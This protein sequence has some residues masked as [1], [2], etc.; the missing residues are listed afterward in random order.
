MIL[1]KF[2]SKINLNSNFTIL[3]QSDSEDVINLVRSNLGFDKIKKRFPKKQTLADIFSL[4]INCDKSIEE[5]I[6]KDYPHFIELLS[7][8]T[9]IKQEYSKFKKQN[10]MLDYDDLLLYLK[11]LLEENLDFRNYI[12]RTYKFIMVDEYQDTNKLQADLVVLLGGQTKNVMVVGDDSQSIYSFRGANFRNI[13][14]FPKQFPDCKII[15]LEENYRSTQSILNFTNEIIAHAKEK[16]P[17]V[18]FTKND[19]GELPSLISAEDDN[20]QSKFVVDK[21]LEL[22]EEGVALN[23]IAVLFRSGFMSYDLEIE[24]NKAGIPFRKFGGLKFI[25]TAHIK[26]LISYLRIIN[27]PIDNISWFRVLLLLPGIGPVKAKRIIEIILQNSKQK[28]FKYQNLNLGK[29]KSE[30]IEKLFETLDKA[31]SDS[32]HPADKLSLIIP[33][34]ETLL[35]NK[36]DDFHKRLKD[37]EIFQI[38]SENYRSLN[39]FLDDLALEPPSSSVY[40]IANTGTENEFLTLSTIHSA[41]GLEWHSVFI[42]S[43]VEGYFPSTYSAESVEDIEEERRLMYVACTRAKRNLF[44]S[45]PLTMFDRGQGT[46]FTKVSRFLTP[47]DQKLFE[48]WTI[49][50]N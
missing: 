22:R 33:H 8:I 6:N 24:L 27:N 13:M 48:E 12:H 38:I 30:Q 39:S 36:Y 26:D 49:N 21:I 5:I 28:N 46:I 29:D 18:L 25:E 34:Y 4:A 35:R 47:I 15:M 7:E 41:K 14:D 19:F 20:L 32:L 3:D 31:N 1:R 17:K 43:A 23:D 37:L 10:S 44:I 40:D 16:Y 11:S 42:L 50:E 9:L 45:F 2:S